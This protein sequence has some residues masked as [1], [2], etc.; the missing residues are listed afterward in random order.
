[1]QLEADVIQ[2]WERL[3]VW[4]CEMLRELVHIEYDVAR[5]LIAGD[6]A[7]LCVGHLLS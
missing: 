1:V 2:Y 4:R 6:G 3:A 7:G 5:R